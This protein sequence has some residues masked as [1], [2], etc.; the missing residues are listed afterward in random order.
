MSSFASAL[1]LSKTWPGCAVI[2]KD[3]RKTRTFTFFVS[4]P[5]GMNRVPAAVRTQ[6]R[7][8]TSF[9]ALMAAGSRSSS[10]SVL[11]GMAWAEATVRP[12]RAACTATLRE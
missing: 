2:K 4:S 1:T 5:T 3:A 12:R 11:K 9:M 6:M 7:W 8:S 10:D